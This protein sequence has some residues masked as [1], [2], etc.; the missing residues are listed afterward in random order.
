MV[1]GEQSL[2]VLAVVVFGTLVATVAAVIVL[3]RSRRTPGLGATSGRAVETVAA[4]M[5]ASRP[6]A[7]P[8]PTGALRRPAIAQRPD[9]LIRV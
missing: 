2:V 8:D 5:L 4:A 9:R 3:V 6:E 1:G 7:E